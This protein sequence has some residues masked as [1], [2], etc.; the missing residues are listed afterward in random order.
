M[1]RRR[2]APPLRTIA[3]AAVL[4]VLGALLTVLAPPASASASPSAPAQ[5]A[6]AT[7]VRGGEALYGASYACTLGFNAVSGGTSYGIIAGHCADVGSTWAVDGESGRVSVGVT[8][9]ASFPGNDYGVVRYTNTS[10]SYPGEVKGSGGAPVDIT[11][12]ADPAPGMSLCHYGRVGG[13]RC[14]TVQAVNLTVNFSGG[15]VSGLFRSNIC[16]EPGDTGGPAFSGGRA[17]GIIV[18]GSGDCT[19]GGVTYYQ[20]IK[21]ILAAYGLTLS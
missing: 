16:S 1:S 21:E 11:G 9:G 7:A 19:S 12:A 3:T 17:V 13:Y 14:G 2:T 20:P 8:S 18:G 5:P 6:A 15:V 4:A 10:L